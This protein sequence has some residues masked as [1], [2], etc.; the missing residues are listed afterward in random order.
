MPRTSR[1]VLTADE[2]AEFASRGED[3]SG[4]FTKK[5]TVVRPVLRGGNPMSVLPDSISAGKRKSRSCSER[6]GEQTAAEERSPGP[7]T[8]PQAD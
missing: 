1:K 6:A 3:V 5:F 8:T 2:I 7:P 4:Y